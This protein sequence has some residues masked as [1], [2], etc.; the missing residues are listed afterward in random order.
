MSL[1]DCALATA[2]IAALSLAVVLVLAAG[3]PPLQ[4]QDQTPPGAG[5]RIDTVAGGGIGDG[6][7]AVQAYFYVGNDGFLSVATD[8]AGN[9]YVTALGS[10]RVRRID[11]TGVISTFAGTGEDGFSGDGGPAA[12]AQLTYPAGVAVDGAG[13]V[14]VADVG[15]HRVRRIDTTGVISTFAGTGEEGFSGDGGPAVEA[16]LSYPVSVAAD[17]AGNV[18]VTDQSNRVRRIDTAGV[19]STFAGTGEEGFSGDGGPAVQAQFYAGH[20][21]FLS[22][23]TDAAGNVYV[24]DSENHR[25]R[26]IDTTGVISTFA[27]TGEEGFSGDGGPA[28]QAQLTYPAGVA[29]DGAGNVYVA[30][31][32]NHRVRRIDTTGVISTFAGTGEEGF[33]GDGGPAVEAA[34]SYPVSVAVDAAGN[35]YLTGYESKR[36]RRIDT[37][38][39]ISTFAGAGEEGFSGDGGPGVLARL[40]S[41]RGVAADG[42]GNLF[43][44]DTGNHRIRKVDSVGV[45]STV[46]GTGEEGFSGDGGPAVQAQTHPHDVAVDGA[47]NL[48]IADYWNHRIRKVDSAGVITT[49]AGTGEFGFSGDGGP[50]VQAQLSSPRGVAVDGAGNLFIADLGNHRIRKVDASGVIT[51]VA[52]TGVLGFGGDGGPAVQA[53][54]YSPFDVVVDGAG[55]LFIADTDNHRI[56]KVDASGVITTVAGTGVL[57]FGGDGGPA[58]QAQLNESRGLAV[59]SAG[60]LFIADSR[61]DR[62]R[63]VDATG[64]IITIAGTGEYGFGGDGGPATAA[65]FSDPDSVAADGTGNVYI[66]ENDNHLVRKLT[67]VGGSGTSHAG[68]ESFSI[69]DRGGRSTTSSGNAETLRVGYGRIRADEGSTTPS[70][71]AIFGFRQNGVLISEAGV[72]A[73]APVQEGRIFAEVDGPVNTGLAIANPNDLP[74]TISFYFTNTSGTRFAEG[75]FELGAHQQTAKFLDQEPF[76]GGPSV[77]GTFT[78]TSSL[79]VAVVALRGFTNAAG[80]FLMTTLPVAPLSSTASDT[81]YFP[82]FADGG[83]WETQVVLVNPTDRTITG[84]AVFLGPGSDTAA[85]S[86]V[87]LTLDDGRTRSDFDYSIAPRSVKRF[88]T[89]NPPDGLT[90]GSVRATPNSGNAA[91]SGLV[92]FSFVSGEK[93]VSEAGVPALPTGS[94]FRVYVEAAGMPGQAGSIRSGLAITNA[95]VATNTVTLEVTNLDG[96]LAVPP[97]TL[98]LPPSGQIARFVDEI[99]TLP[100]N[101][102]GVLRVTSTSELAIVGLRLRTNE[103]GELKMTTTPPSNETG[104][105]TTADVF[106]PHIADSGG[107]STQFILYSGTAGQTAAGTLSFIDTSGQPLDLPTQNSVS[108]GSASPD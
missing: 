78:F 31:V 105:S 8:T 13:N 12:Q 83:G 32:E 11:T 75:S 79:P 25:V 76:N 21:G 60:N 4:A 100:D 18:Y 48:F 3:S 40:S 16:A 50:A 72:P 23:A 65:Q 88:T 36:V 102:S 53:Q 69:P 82:H 39:V 10:H 74:A 89:S 22:V 24:S 77:L 104:P 6:G 91:P 84:T 30:D 94:A 34:L 66:T 97:A 55:N 107:W 95:G 14:Y 85:A 56:R 29:V 20:D 62:I 41:P 9:V 49:I 101:F 58:V 90:V 2:A 44:A 28:A 61:N 81:V 27:G 71:I 67:P 57:G 1:R 51:T 92:V 106:F 93:T 99:F 47:G 46:A 5:Y 52:G 42:A 15:N 45:I 87:V 108:E 96:S 70:G 64:T 103:N 98:A 59:D 54:L 35:V 86:P 43:I 37:A 33:S 19:I 17:G 7:P 26:R 73:S 38:G 68:A 63:K 80:E